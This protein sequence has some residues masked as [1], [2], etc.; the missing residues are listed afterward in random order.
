MSSSN[1]LPQWL[2]RLLLTICNDLTTRHGRARRAA[3]RAS[4]ADLLRWSQTFLPNHFTLPPSEMHRWL[5]RGLDHLTDHR[6]RK[7]NVLAP[8]GAAKSTLAA[9]AYPLREALEGREPYIWILSDTRRQAYAHLENIKVELVANPAL[10]AAYP[11][12]AGRGPVWQSGSIVLPNGIALEAFGTGQRIRGRRFRAHR[13]SLILCDDLESDRHVRSRT[14]RQQSRDWFHG[15]LMKAGTPR[16]NVVNLATALHRDAL[17]LSLAGTPGWETRIFRAIIRWPDAMPLWQQWEAIY[18]AVDRP[19][20]QA[21][22]RRFYRQHRAEMDAGARVL[23]PELEDLY[24]LMAMRAEGGR[25]AFEREKQ[26]S[27]V[28]PDQCEWPEE[29]FDD[30][31]WF[32]RW[33]DRL[34]LKTLAID[35][36]KGADSR[37]GDY[38]AIVMVGI[39]RRGVLYV[40]ADLARRPIAQI[41]ADGV[42]LYRR[43]QPALFGIETN[44]FQE[45]LG[46]QFEDEFRRQGILAPRPTLLDNHVNKLVRI[47][48]LGSYLATRHLKMKSDS[49]GTRLLVD[50]LR[51]FP[52]GDHDDGPDA[53]EMAVRLA[54]QIAAHATRSDNLPPRLHLG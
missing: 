13:P 16:S 15:T 8:R 17:A 14:A 54:E 1:W 28:A 36:S 41:V 2:K 35:P 50:Q 46:S 3:A 33:P 51:D 26:N 23:W 20:A 19:D 6:G 53:L 10:A 21:A 24:T 4:T 5:A 12:A 11:G 40:E 48:R 31:L 43:F 44:Q 47:R 49:P 32:D 22:A 7:L 18:A 38:S 34:L 27:P 45:L 52:V 30:S 29:Y 42:A 37:R 9:L 39:D 25:T